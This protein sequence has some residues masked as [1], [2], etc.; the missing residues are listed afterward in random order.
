[1][2]FIETLLKINAR[3]DED[4]TKTILNNISY[5][6]PRN[7]FFISWTL[8]HIFNASFSLDTSSIWMK[9]IETTS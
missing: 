4:K 7:I 2:H 3:Y 9:R 5:N 8:S 1:M 6:Y